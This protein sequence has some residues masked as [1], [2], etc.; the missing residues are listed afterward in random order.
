MFML[1]VS[2]IKELTKL[3]INP[4]T[5]TYTFNSNQILMIRDKS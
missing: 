3:I 1:I 2:V 5:Y 4:L